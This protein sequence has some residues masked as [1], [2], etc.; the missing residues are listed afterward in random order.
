[1]LKHSLNFFFEQEDK[2][3][4]KNCEVKP[5]KIQRSKNNNEEE[6]EQVGPVR[7]WCSIAI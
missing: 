2:N 4:D 7:C 5:T 6:C 1:M 3:I